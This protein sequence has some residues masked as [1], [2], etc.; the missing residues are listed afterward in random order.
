MMF[1]RA[2]DW[3]EKCSLRDLRLDEAM[4]EWKLDFSSCVNT[5]YLTKTC[6]HGCGVVEGDCPSYVASLAKGVEVGLGF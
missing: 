4:P 3:A 5:K 2:V 6:L 1:R